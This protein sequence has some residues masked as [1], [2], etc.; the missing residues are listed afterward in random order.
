MFSLII[1]TSK[2]CL[3]LQNVGMQFFFFFLEYN[4]ISIVGSK[5]LILPFIQLPILSNFCYWDFLTSLFEQPTSLR[6]INQ[7]SLTRTTSQQECQLVGD[8][9]IRS[10]SNLLSWSVSLDKCS[11][12]A[13][14][15]LMEWLLKS[16]PLE[17]GFCQWQWLQT[18]LGSQE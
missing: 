10:D 18:W 15:S 7:P 9:M 12:M 17:M 16:L 1:K 3:V 4:S 5:F 11:S 8:K 2:E 13:S 14:S 6:T